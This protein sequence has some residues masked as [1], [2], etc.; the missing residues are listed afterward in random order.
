[1][2]NVEYVDSYTSIP[3]AQAYRSDR[4]WLFLRDQTEYVSPSLRL[5]TGTDSE[6]GRLQGCYAAW[7]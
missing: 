1:M 2:G 3:L 4:V 7:L 5:R 6:K